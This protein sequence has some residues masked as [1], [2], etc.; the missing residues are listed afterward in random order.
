VIRQ[1]WELQTKFT[2]AFVV[3]ER[4]EQIRAKAVA[5]EEERRAQ[6]AIDAAQE[7]ARLRALEVEGQRVA[8]HRAAMTAAKKEGE[9]QLQE[10]VRCW[11]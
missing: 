7:E 3:L 4:S 2:I 1:R 9:K 11:G 5:G 6:A 10:K 8:E